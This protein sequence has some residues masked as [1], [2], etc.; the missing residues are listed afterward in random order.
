MNESSVGMSTAQVALPERERSGSVREED[1]VK[2]L[3][4][5]AVEHCLLLVAVLLLLAFMHWAQA[6]LVPLLF[7]TL[8]SYTLNPAVDALSRWRVPRAAGAILVLGTFSTACGALVYALSDDAVALTELVPH[9]ATKIR[10]IARDQR[11]DGSP[12]PLANL[13]KAATELERA[14]LEAAGGPGPVRPSVSNSQLSGTVQQWMV[15]QASHVVRAC[16]EFG[17]ALLFAF[18]LL[19]AG[20]AFRRKVA[21]LAGPSLA[22]RRVAI[23][24]LNE[25][26]M[27]IQRYMATIAITNALIAVGTWGALAALG[28]E[29]A[30]FWGVLAGL[31]HII[32][33]VGSSF[34]AA[35]VGV[36]ALVQFDDPYQIA[37]CV[38]A[39]LLV[40]S[41]IGLVFTT[42]LQA[43]ACRVNNVV[44]ITGV[45][46]FG[47]LWGGWGLILAVPILTTLRTIAESLEQWRPLAEF[48]SE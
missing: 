12:K 38:G 21:R 24:T 30:L 19:V 14:A 45:L 23:E 17:T 9:A 22:R 41:L 3:S 4:L 29:H 32:P 26:D 27:R 11:V 46:F 25:V 16:V 8:L 10:A 15:A 34:A 28:L 5:S 33:Y 42:W 47:W 48:L 44:I 20:D 18:F 37:L 1:G 40:A 36:V 6:F 39:V 2:P 13:Q 35:A 7:G 31:L 43:R